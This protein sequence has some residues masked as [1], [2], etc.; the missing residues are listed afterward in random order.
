MVNAR[1]NAV[2]QRFAGGGSARLKSLPEIVKEIADALK[3]D[4]QPNKRIGAVP[5][6]R[7]A[8]ILRIDRERQAFEPTPA[9]ADAEM[10]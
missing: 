3:P 9:I 1:K 10:T 2:L 7:T 8:A 4:V 5:Y 6:C